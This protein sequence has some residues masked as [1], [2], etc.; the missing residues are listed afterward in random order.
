MKNYFVIHALGNTENNYWYKYIKNYVENQGFS[1][2]VP[3]LPE[4]GKMS[5]QSWAK[6]FD[7]YKS[8]INKDSIVIGHSTGSIFL[9]KYLMEN[10]LKVDKFIGV[11]SFN[12]V[13]KKLTNPEWD[14]INQSFFVTNLKEFVKHAKERICFL[15]S[16]RYF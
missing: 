15:F 2:V 5:Y 4:I 3:T 8:L 1:C 9:V 16:H 10:N 7:K 12:N 14:K 6:E 13:N 11:V